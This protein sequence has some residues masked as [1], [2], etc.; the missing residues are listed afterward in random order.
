MKIAS[1]LWKWVGRRQL[2]PGTDLR[3]RDNG[4]GQPIILEQL[5]DGIVVDQRVLT[6]NAGKT[7]ML[8]TWVHWHRDTDERLVFRVE[9]RTQWDRHDRRR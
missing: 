6:S 4:P 1:W 3:Y 9:P 8:G 5:S 2:I 7:P